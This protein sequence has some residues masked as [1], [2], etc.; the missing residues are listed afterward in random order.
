MREVGSNPPLSDSPYRV[1]LPGKEGS[2]GPRQ[3]IPASDR[4]RPLLGRP[5]LPSACSPLQSWAPSPCS[6]LSLKSKLP[7]NFAASNNNAISVHPESRSGVAGRFWLRV[8]HGVESRCQPG[9][10]SSEGWTGAGGA[11]SLPQRPGKLVP[12]VGRSPR[13][14][15]TWTSPRGHL[16]ALTMWQPLPPEPVAQERARRKPQG[17]L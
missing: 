11:V 4:G 5:L 14:L 15:S 6:N 2:G 3:H 12:A 7:R 9:L 8:S 17:L 1:G 13:L 10:W 16:S